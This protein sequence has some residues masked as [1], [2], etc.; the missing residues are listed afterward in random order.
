M[1]LAGLTGNIAAGKSTV[2]DFF[3]HKGATLIDADVLARDAVAPGT[4]GFEAVIKRWGDK[5]R[6]ADGSLDRAALRAIVFA[7]P[8]EREALN[9]IIHPRVEELRHQA[10][11]KARERGDRIVVCDIPLLYEKDLAG[12]FD[13]VVL[14][15]APRGLRLQRLVRERALPIA[16]AEAMIDAQM[17]ADTKRT[18]AD[19]IINNAGTHAQLE[20]RILE[21]WQALTKAERLKTN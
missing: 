3:V 9:G 14:V 16:E 18:R 21:V 20:A 5:V 15:D 10:V 7:D 2:A 19:Y 13:C 8:G 17:P 11:T 1:L 12:L 4:P 6:T